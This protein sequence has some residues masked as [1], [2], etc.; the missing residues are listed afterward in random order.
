MQKISRTC[1][2]LLVFLAR[3]KSFCL[4][5]IAI[6]LKIGIGNIETL[7]NGENFSSL[8]FNEISLYSEMQHF[9][10]IDFV[11]RDPIG[12][13]FQQRS[14]LQLTN[15]VL[16]SQTGILFTV[17]GDIITESSSWSPEYLAATFQTKPFRIVPSTKLLDKRPAINLTS[18]GFYH[19]LNEDLP[20][21]LHLNRNLVNPITVVSS[22][23][24]DFVNSFLKDFSIEYQEV[25]RFS[26]FEEINFIS[27]KSTVGW[28]HPKDVE[29]LK[30][31]F[32]QYLN[33]RTVG[34]RVYI[35]RI[36]DSRSPLFERTLINLLTNSGWKVLDLKDLS[37]VEQ[38]AEISTAEVLMGVHG[39]G[40]SGVNWMKEGS[41]LI[42]LGTDR[43]VRCFQRLAQINKIDY[44]RINYKTDSEGLNIVKTKLQNLGYL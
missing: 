33:E 25:P 44:L 9:S 13:T 42:E 22:K 36:S 41:K 23:R 21:Y 18:N 10:Y 31:F 20:Q 7:I 3:V 29:V 12:I 34:K 6:R 28:P 2:E 11:S 15:T 27:K 26:H 19:W 16:D 5:K 14:H 8:K 1:F 30:E 37:L 24:P 32:K 39:A 35:S 38:V 17:N 4:R 40:L 43:F